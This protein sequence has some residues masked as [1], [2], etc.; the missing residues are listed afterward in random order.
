ML[1]NFPRKN[2]DNAL[3]CFCKVTKLGR[4]LVIFTSAE[5]YSLIQ[6]KVVIFMHS[7]KRV[8]YIVMV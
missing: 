3:S 5:Y 1:D 6:K 2:L 4:Y 8:W 7:I